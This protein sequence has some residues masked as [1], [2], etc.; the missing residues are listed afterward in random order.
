[1][2][3]EEKDGALLA[4]HQGEML[5]IE[6]WGEDSLRVRATKLGGFTNEDWALTEPVPAGNAVV[7]IGEM[8]HRLS[9]GVI[10]TLCPAA[11]EIALIEVVQIFFM[12]LRVDTQ[13]VFHRLV[14]TPADVI[15]A[16]QIVHEPAVVRQGVE[17]I[18]LGFHD[19]I[20]QIHRN[21]KSTK[22]RHGYGTTACQG[23]LEKLRTDITPCGKRGGY[24]F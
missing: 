12:L 21:K 22:Q 23:P 4:Y 6:S 24:P 18:Q 14:Q 9:S 7:K 13:P 3:F 16:A 2:R 5:R 17:G 20:Q 19:F 8:D 1:M 11:G 10:V 15:V